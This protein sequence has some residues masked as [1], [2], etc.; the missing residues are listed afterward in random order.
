MIFILVRH[1][2]VE[3]TGHECPKTRVYTRI[4]CRIYRFYPFDRNNKADRHVHFATSHFRLSPWLLRVFPLSRSIILALPC[5]I[6]PRRYGA[7]CW[8][9][10]PVQCVRI[11]Y[12][13]HVVRVSV[14]G[15]LFPI[16][17]LPV[18]HGYDVKRI[19]L[20]EIS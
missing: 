1:K 17:S 13:T 4:P 6:C 5:R 7:F 11:V 20:M 19:F 18:A 12:G 3:S 10:R 14:P 8:L 9:S 16:D 15:A 2:C